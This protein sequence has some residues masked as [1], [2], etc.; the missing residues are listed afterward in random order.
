MAKKKKFGGI[1]DEPLEPL[2]IGLLMDEEQQNEAIRKRVDIEL[3]K[4]DQLSEYYEL[5]VGDYCSLAL[6]LAREFIAGFKEAKPKGRPAKWDQVIRG[7]LYV[8]VERVARD[9]GPKKRYANVAKKP[10]WAAFI[11]SVDALNRDADPAEAVRKQYL[12]AKSDHFRKVFWKAYQW[13]ESL[14][15]VEEWD[16][17]VRRELQEQKANRRN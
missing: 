12:A 6:A 16:K 14:G 1:L 8:D 10:H 13:H 7:Y 3:A 17:E 9:F 11:D 5:R 2:E 4:L 15:T